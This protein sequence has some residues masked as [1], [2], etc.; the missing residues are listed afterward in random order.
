MEII[1]FILK[2]SMSICALTAFFANERNN[3]E[4]SYKALIWAVLNLITYIG[5][6]ELVN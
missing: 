2:I 5:I 6:K 1:Q 3:K 4:L